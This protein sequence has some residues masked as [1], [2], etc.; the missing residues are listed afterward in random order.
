MDEK[1]KEKIK[2]KTVHKF[3]STCTKLSLENKLNVENVSKYDDDSDMSEISVEDDVD[4]SEFSKSE[5]KPVKVLIP[6]NS[7]VFARI[8]EIILR[9]KKKR[10]LFSK[11]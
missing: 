2:Y 11:G 8:S 4:C 7:V 9:F 10:L 3:D 1:D 5:P 6:E